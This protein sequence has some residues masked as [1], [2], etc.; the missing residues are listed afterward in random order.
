VGL[1]NL[2]PVVASHL[3]AVDASRPPVDGA[4]WRTLTTANARQLFPAG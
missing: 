1:L 2:P 4:T 3:A